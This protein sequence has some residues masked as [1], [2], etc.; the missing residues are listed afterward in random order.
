MSLLQNRIVGL[1]S[2][3]TKKKIWK[4][5][6]GHLL[7]PAKASAGSCDGCGVRVASGDQVM[8]CKTCNWYLCTGCHPQEREPRSWFWSSISFVADK[9]SQ[10]LQDLKEVSELA[11]TMGPLAACA[12]P[13]V[14]K[15]TEMDFGDVTVHR[16]TGN[17]AGHAPRTPVGGAAPVTPVGGAAPAAAETNEATPP[18]TEAP[19]V[20]PPIDLLG[21]DCE[22]AK[23]V[24]KLAPPP[25]AVT[26]Q[27]ELLDLL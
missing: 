11:E 25:A 14:A 7:Q 18:K 6:S 17:N 20:E 26:T 23:P 9:A 19:K 4:C 10:E 5:P 12:A 3:G 1:G 27:G 24:P 21:L 2:D 15:D 16:D 8:E 13:P 22:V